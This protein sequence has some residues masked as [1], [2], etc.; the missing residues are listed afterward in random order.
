M[1]RAFDLPAAPAD[2]WPWFAQLGRRRAGWYLPHNI[3]RLLPRAGRGLRRLDPRFQKIA[4]GDVIPTGRA[5]TTPL[6]SRS[7]SS[8]MSWCTV[9]PDA[10]WRSVGRSCCTMSGPRKRRPL[11]YTSG[12]GLGP[13]ATGLVETVGELIDLLTVAGLAAGL[14]ERLTP[15][16]G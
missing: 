13:S 5:A 4:V 14:R 2:V 7:S 15:P 8:P 11:A 3:E 1:D 6:R 16:P 9:P 12:F 10:P